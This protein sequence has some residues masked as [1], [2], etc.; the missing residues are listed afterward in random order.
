MWSDVIV[1]LSPAGD[2]GFSFFQ[3]EK[4]LAIEQFVAQLAIE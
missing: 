3:G 1:L 2:Q 4:D